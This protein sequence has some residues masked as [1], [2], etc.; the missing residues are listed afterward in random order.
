MSAAELR[1]KGRH[2]RGYQRVEADAYFT[3]DAPWIVP[4]L[5]DHVAIAGRIL[6]PCAGRGHLARELRADGLDVVAEDLHAHERLVI[7]FVKP[8]ADIFEKR[9]L[10]GF[11]W[12]ISNFPYGAQ[13]RMLRRLLPIA[14]RD[15]C[16]VALLTRHQWTCAQARRDIVHEHPNFAGQIVLTSRPVW[17]EGTRGGGKD[18]YA[19]VVWSPEPRP[20][21]AAP[22]LKF[23]DKR[24]RARG[25]RLTPIP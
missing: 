4:A 25:S 16:G 8:G 23:A 12:L 9:S 3:L 20:A 15:G 17:I 6:E 19:W 1:P 24:E 14:A 18:D 5:L 7:D 13:D 11:S 21:S 10:A 2:P 22:F